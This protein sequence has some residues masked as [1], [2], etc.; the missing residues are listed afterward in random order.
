[1]SMSV[2]GVS[3]TANSVTH[4]NDDSEGYTNASVNGGGNVIRDGS[5][6][7]DGDYD[8]DS[9]INCGDISVNNYINSWKGHS[10]N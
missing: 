6:I 10:Q 9:N 2:L 1:M 4:D 5:S 8:V 7:N 3:D